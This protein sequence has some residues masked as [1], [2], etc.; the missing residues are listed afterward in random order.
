MISDFS[1]N[2][3]YSQIFRLGHFAE[4]ED[5]KVTF[6][7]NEDSWSYLNIRFANFDND[8]FVR[9]LGSIDKSKVS[10]VNAIDGYTKFNVKNVESTETVLTTIPAEDGWTL[11]I[12]GA[13]AELKTYQNAFIAFDVPSG[14]HTAELV[15][16]APGLKTGAMAS[17]AG[18]VL[19]AVFVA[20]D[21]MI[22]KKKKS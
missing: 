8:T 11:Y 1:S 3:Y 20:A 14:E 22:A 6:L 4:G 17:C 12:D 7:S 13:P 16:T 10:V 19:L 9:Q 5:V 21:K 18:V 2:T 15:F